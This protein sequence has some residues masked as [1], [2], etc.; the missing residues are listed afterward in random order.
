MSQFLCNN[1]YVAA[2]AHELAP[3][4]S[5]SRRVCDKPVVLFR[6]ENGRA[7]ALED[8]CSHRAMPLSAGGKCER[9]IIRCP[10]HG[11][12]F[13][14]HGNCVKIPTQPTVPSAA[15]IRSYPVIE[16]DAMLWIWVGDTAA[17]DD[18]LV[19][20]WLYH[21]DPAWEWTSMRL[22]F[23]ADAMLVIEN[24]MDMT[25][26]AFVHDAVI[27]GDP[28]AQVNATTTVNPAPRGVK[29]IRHMPNCSPPP[30]YQMGAQFK[31]KIDRWQ[32]FEFVPGIVRFWTGG[33]DVGTGAFEGRREGGVQLRHLHAITP[34]GPNSCY[35]HTTLAR[36]F[37][38]GN[39]ELGEKLKEGS[40][41]TIDVEDRKIIEAQQARILEDPER[42]MVD[43][44]ADAAGIQ[45][46]RIMRT[47]ID[48]QERAAPLA[49][50]IENQSH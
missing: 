49:P 2:F 46:R 24:L 7:V 34:K 27:N 16:L 21:A 33:V 15:R 35:Y 29:V 6:T 42:R 44:Q 8:R 10:Y 38:L 40:R 19:P 23:N 20:R 25:H 50:C 32:E 26:I 41:I 4:S 45:A 30:Q 36:N 48:A 11:L 1:W 13:D 12:E 22:E 47:L 37:G 17:C 43:I 39:A 31:G 14:E 18:K 3:G 5:L 28:D 9:N